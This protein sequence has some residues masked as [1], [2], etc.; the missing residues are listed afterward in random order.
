MKV[1]YRFI[2]QFPENAS[3]YGSAELQALGRVW[4]ERRAA[5]R[6]SDAFRE[7]LKRLQREWAIETGII[8]RLYT[9]DRGVTEVLIEQGIESSVIAHYSGM[10]RD[11]AEH[12]KQIID[13]QLGIVDGLFAYVKGDQPLTE[14]FIRGLQAQF[15]EHQ[16]D[17]EALT[18]DGRVI[19]VLIEKGKYKTLPN[20]PRRPDGAMHAYCPPE[21]TQE[22]MTRLIDWYRSNEAG[23][24][25]EV[26]A[27]WLHHRFTQIHPFQDGNG[28]VAR[29]LASL[30]FLKAGFFPLVI[31]DGDRQEYIGALEAADDGDLKPLV[32]LFARRQK[33]AILHALGLEQQVQQ[34]RHAEAIIASAL[35]VLK[36]KY[37]ASQRQVGLVDECADSLFAIA[38]AR[39]QEIAGDLDGQL[40][41]L[42]PPRQSPYRA[43][44]HSA[45]REG[46][47]RHYFYKQIVDVAHLHHYFANLDRY[48][49][50][51]RISITTADRF[52]IVV[53]LHGYGHGDTGV[54]AASA[55]TSRRVEREEGGNEYVDLRPA[56]V[57]LFQFNYAEARES[58]V[59]RFKDWLEGSLAIALAEWQ[60]LIAA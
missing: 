59:E 36:G 22:K 33:E 8:E 48:R 34:S 40:A 11:Q 4:L 41:A 52:E 47:N 43:Q 50:W 23:L 14:H 24:P 46:D 51:V 56:C 53:S 38:Q 42:T 28:R 35:Q 32:G 7:F 25:P 19:R 13:D 6:E 5:L 20:N 3:A 30:V 12:I 9:W 55:F 54:M 45:G 1:T 2:A 31:R 21:L 29:A 17:T 16:D 26:N 44:L 10:R 15:T 39:M 57:D 58:T 37:D 49:A 60:R 18:I 27:A